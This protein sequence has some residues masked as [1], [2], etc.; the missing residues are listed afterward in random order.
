MKKLMF[1]NKYNN[2]PL[3]K[4]IVLKDPN[5][6]VDNVLLAIKNK[7]VKVNDV[8]I[9]NDVIVNQFDSIVIFYKPVNKMWYL[10]IFDDENILIVFKR[11]G[12]EV[13]S[14]KDRSL[15]GVLNLSYKVYPVHRIDRNTE[16]L[17]IF[18]KHKIAEIALTKAFKD[19]RVIKRYIA[20]VKGKLKLNKIKDTL[21]L[22]KNSESSKVDISSKP[23][24]GYEQIITKISVLDF[25]EKNT[26][27]EAE[28]VTGKTH[29]I[30]AHLSYYG[31][32][33]V[34]D[35]KYGTKDN[36]KQMCLTAYKLDFNFDKDSL[37]NYMNEKHIEITPSWLK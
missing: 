7:D 8:K 4:A 20:L 30:R 2:I 33:I 21:Y 24:M 17:V 10:P 27:V 11:A 34:G 6:S 1:I 13:V 5:L 32:P 26:L 19:R 16:G 36:D 23:Q 12:I 15:E 37:L 14:E 18:A 25:F 9:E 3:S 28:L 22:K 29:Q 31:Y 35:G